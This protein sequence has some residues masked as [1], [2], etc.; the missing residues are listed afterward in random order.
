MNGRPAQPAGHLRKLLAP[1]EAP[2]PHPLSVSLEAGGRMGPGSPWPMG[3]GKGAG[4]S[5]SLSPPQT[6]SGLGSSQPGACQSRLL[7]GGLVLGAGALQALPAR[8]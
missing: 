8:A 7:L 3:G 4:T 2:A 5:P 6:L 1:A